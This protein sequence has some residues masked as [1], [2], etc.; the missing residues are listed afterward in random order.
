[1]KIIENVEKPVHFNITF[2]VYQRE[3]KGYIQLNASYLIHKET[4]P[5]T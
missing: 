5:K 2:N 3:I 1:M 4:L